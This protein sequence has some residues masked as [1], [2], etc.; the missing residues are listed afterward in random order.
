M[1]TILTEKEEDFSEK[2]LRKAEITCRF[3]NSDLTG[4]L[5]EIENYIGL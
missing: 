3:E 2:N 4:C 1:N 5:K